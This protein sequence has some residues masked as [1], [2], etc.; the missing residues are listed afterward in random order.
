MYRQID[1]CLYL[2]AKRDHSQYDCFVFVLLSHGDERDIIYGSDQ[3]LNI[4]NLT[5]PF[6]RS[7]NSL[8]GKPKI[9]IF[10]VDITCEHRSQYDF[11]SNRLSRHVED[12][13]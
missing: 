3:P 4:S 7:A 2:A 5:E 9:F 12:R 11:D 13:K 8:L 10:Q 6:K 1:C